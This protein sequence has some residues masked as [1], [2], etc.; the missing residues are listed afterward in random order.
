MR[1]RPPRP[2]GAIAT[3]AMF[4]EIIPAADRL[5]NKQRQ[6]YRQA[7]PTRHAHQQQGQPDQGNAEQRRPEYLLDRITPHQPS[8]DL[9]SQDQTDPDE[10]KTPARIVSG[11]SLCNSIRTKEEP[12]R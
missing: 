4:G 12:V 7:A 1:C 9:G 6:Q 10:T 3:A 5:R 8:V 2:N 11:V